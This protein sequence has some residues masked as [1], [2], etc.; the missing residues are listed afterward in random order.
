MVVVAMIASNKGMKEAFSPRT[1]WNDQ[2]VSHFW[3]QFL[4]TY[5]SFF[6]CD[7]S[8]HQKPF[9]KIRPFGRLSQLFSIYGLIKL[10]LVK[11]NIH[12]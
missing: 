8:L 9:Y 5:L 12:V 2:I 6:Q 7:V 10:K 4:T 3:D 11:M 1:I